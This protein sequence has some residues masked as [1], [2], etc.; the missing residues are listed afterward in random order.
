VE[1]NLSWE[2]NSHSVYQKIPPLSWNTKVHCSV[3]KSPPLVP[4]LSQMNPF[5][6]I[7]NYFSKIPSNN[8]LQYTPSSF[9][10]S[11]NSSFS[12]KNFVFN[13]HLFMRA[14]CPAYLI[15]HDSITL[16]IFGETYKLWN[17]LITHSFSVFRHCLHFMSSYSPQHPVLKHCQCALPLMWETKFRAH[18]KQ[19]IKII[20]LC[21]L[22]CTF[23]IGDR[24]TKDSELN[25]IKRSL[26][27]IYCYFRPEWNF[28]LMP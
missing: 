23:F 11:L 8:I 18:T 15:L 17:F 28:S 1:H 21:I 26:N 27:L 22:I 25:G 3:H 24:K 7:W 19:K 6:S 13:F 9:E 12:H 5:H 2:A 16:T 20:V 14:A 4:V 10:W